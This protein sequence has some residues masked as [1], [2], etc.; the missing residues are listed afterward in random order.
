MKRI[1]FFLA[2]VPVLLFLADLD[3]REPQGPRIEIS[4]E[5]MDLG[6]VAEGSLVRQVFEITNAG[7]ETLIIER[8][9]PG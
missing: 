6:K 2:L 8:L 1:P 5:S 9:Q 4:G 3:A 7:D